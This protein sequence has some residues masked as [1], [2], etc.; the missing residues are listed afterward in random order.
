MKLQHILNYGLLKHIEIRGRLQRD[1]SMLVEVLK[2]APFR[3][4]KELTQ[5][6]KDN[7]NSTFKS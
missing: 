2:Y 3:I 5:V 7:I 1:R 6:Y 4:I